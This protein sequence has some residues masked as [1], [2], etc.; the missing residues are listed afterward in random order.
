MTVNEPLA[1]FKGKFIEHKLK[2]PLEI[3]YVYRNKNIK[4]RVEN[5]IGKISPKVEQTKRWKIR[6]KKERIFPGSPNS[7]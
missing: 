6:K 7:E 3:N 1:A 4:E 5:K 2:I